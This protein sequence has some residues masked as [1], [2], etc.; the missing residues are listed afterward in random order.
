MVDDKGGMIPELSA[1]RDGGFMNAHWLPEFRSNSGKPFSEKNHAAFW[2][3]DLLYSIAGNFPCSP[4]FGPGGELDGVAHPPH[5]WTANLTWKHCGAGVDEESGAAWA[6]STLRSPDK[7]LPL[8]WRKIDVVMPGSPVH[9]SSLEI[10]NSG[11]ADADINVGWHNTI[12]APFLQAGCRLS[13]S[14]DRFAVAPSGG[15]FDL[16]GR[17]ALGAEF[18]SLSKAPLRTGKTCDLRTVP[19]MIGF[20]DL[21]TGPVPR[22]APLGW[23]AVANP[24]LGYAYVCFFPGPEAAGDGG[25]A[26]AFNDLWMQYGGRNFTPWAAYEGGTDRTFCLG[27]EN[28]TG[29]YANGLDYARQTKELLGAPTT[30]RIPGKGKRTL[31]YG[32][33]LAP[34]SGGTL[35]GGVVS[36]EPEKGKIALAGTGKTVRVSADASFAVLASLERRLP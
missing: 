17:L 23:T 13:V 14:A 28:A 11:E 29:A 18:K 22:R 32:T 12:G 33:L 35:D 8:R 20:T 24:V 9:Y 2:H 30:V 10:S 21:I 3:V 6:V 26:L 7:K 5:G 16:T 31:R 1:V 25:I 4:N 27:T 34:Y 36:V 15:E 19:G